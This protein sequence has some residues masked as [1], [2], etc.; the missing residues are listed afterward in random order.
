MQPATRIPN[1]IVDI[2][3]GPAGG[4]GKS[5]KFPLHAICKVELTNGSK[6][7]KATV[8]IYGLSESSI[9][10]IEQKNQTIQLFAGED[11]PG[12]AFA[13]DI[14]SRGVITKV[15]P[16]NRITTIKC[17]DGRRVWREAKF[18]KSYPRG[19]TRFAVL[20]DIIKALGLPVGYLSTR[21]RDLVF[22]TGWAF[23]G[24]ARDAL[25]QI[26]AIDNARY[27]IQSGIL[28]ILA[29]DEVEPGNAPLISAA[30]GMKESPQRTDKGVTVKAVLNLNLR[31]GRPF[32]VSSFGVQGDY[33]C[34]KANHDFSTLG[35]IWES[36][37]EGKPLRGASAG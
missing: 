5:F 30:T 22:A 6:P 34:T 11:L 13:G 28:Q 23:A 1:R 26:L 36:R 21:L 7:N 32:K 10:F 4:V 35:L 29:Q 33:K 3:I 8:D 31:P 17:A 15:S 20:Q 16:P 2:Q 9:R 24:K 14:A 19:I 12:R 27:S 18:S 37:A 25:T